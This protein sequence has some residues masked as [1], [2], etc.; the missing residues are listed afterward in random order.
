VPVTPVAARSSAVRLVRHRVAR[1]FQHRG[2]AGSVNIDHP[3]AEARGGDACLRDGV[4]DVVKLEVEKDAKA[5]PHQFAH[6]P[7]FRD[8]E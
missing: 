3:Y 4:R 2:A 8:G 6:Q 5:S 7:C 1:G